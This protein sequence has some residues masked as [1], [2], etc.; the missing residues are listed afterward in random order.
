MNYQTAKLTDYYKE[1]ARRETALKYVKLPNLPVLEFGVFTGASIAYIH[2][3]LSETTIGYRCIL[4]FDSFI[5]LPKEYDGLKVHAEWS[6]GKFDSRELF[7]LKDVDAVIS[8]LYAEFDDFG[9][10]VV[11]FPGYYKDSLTDELAK[12]VQKVSYVGIDSDLYISACQALDWVF[13]HELYTSGTVLYYDNWGSGEKYKGG[14]WKAH[15]DKT[16][17]YGIKCDL[18]YDATNHEPNSAFIIQ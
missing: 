1:A 4:G 6:E 2:K 12:E 14:E 11:L 17:E 15:F 9:A 8:K 10:R 13:R 7:G 16:R 3:Y 5:G 18:L